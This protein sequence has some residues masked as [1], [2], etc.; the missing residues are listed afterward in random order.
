[1]VWRAHA[2][3]GNRACGHSGAAR[4]R[5]LVGGLSVS[6]SAAGVRATYGEG[7][8][9]GEAKQ[10]S[11]RQHHGDEAEEGLQGSGVL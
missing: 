2:R 4:L 8:E 6:G 11:L 7:I 1:M 10:G 3:R 9:Q 5:G